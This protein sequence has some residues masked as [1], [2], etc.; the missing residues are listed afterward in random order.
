MLARDKQ[1]ELSDQAADFDIRNPS[2]QL[3]SSAH[4]PRDATPQLRTICDDP[5]RQQ[6]L[7]LGLGNSM[8]AAGRLNTLYFD[9]V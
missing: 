8:M 3:V 7:Y 6:T 2:K 1:S 9:L 5:T 4:T